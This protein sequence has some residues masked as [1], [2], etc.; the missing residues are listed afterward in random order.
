M[1]MEC[2][3][4]SSSVPANSRICPSCGTDCGYPNVRLARAAA[5]EQALGHRIED[6]EQSAAVKGSTEVLNRFRKV[7]DSSE[8]TVARPLSEVQN[9]L[10]NRNNSYVSH[11]R[12]VRAGARAVED[13]EFDPIRTQ[14]ENAVFPNFHDEIVFAALSL[15]ASG[16]KG[17]GGCIIVLKDLMIEERTSVFEENPYTFARRHSLT[18][19]DTIPDG[20]RA[21][22]QCR[23]QLAVAKL[24]GRIDA[25]TR[26]EE[27]AGILMSDD[28][29]TGGSDFIEVHI[30]GTIN[31]NAIEK[32]AASPPQKRAEVLTW[33][34]IKEYAKDLGIDVEEV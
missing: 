26:T 16:L 5:N 14:F 18:M 22:W 3:K 27:F 13:N 32:I 24:H 11:H 10:A 33:R 2:P 12:M 28:G 15:N 21:T 17:Y 6:A 23:A 30:Y 1:Y 19:N 8:A 31:S 25:N 29:T 4:C 9:L 20:Y 34:A 7:V